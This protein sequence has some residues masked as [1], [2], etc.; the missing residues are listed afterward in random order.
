[1]P[2]FIEL[3]RSSKIKGPQQVGFNQDTWDDVYAKISCPDAIDQ[4]LHAAGIWFGQEFTK[5]R[6]I[7]KELI[8]YASVADPKRFFIGIATREWLVLARKLDDAMRNYSG[9]AIFSGE[10][11]QAEITTVFGTK[12]TPEGL[13]E[14]L[15]DGIR[16]PLST[17][18]PSSAPTVIT[19]PIAA[20]DAAAK[21]FFTAQLYH[22]LEQLWLDLTWNDYRF[23]EKDGNI[24]ILPSN[25][26]VHRAKAISGFRRQA[27]QVETIHTAV[28]IWKHKLPEEIRNRGLLERKLFSIIKKP[29]GKIRIKVS[30]AARHRDNPYAAP[31]QHIFLTHPYTDEYVNHAAPQLNNLTI[32]Q[33]LI[34]YDL[35]SQLPRQMA[36]FLPSDT[37]IGTIED[38]MAC[39]PELEREELYNAFRKALSISD[40]QA[41]FLIDRMTHRGSVR[42]QLWFKPII[43]LGNGRI[44]LFLPAIDGIHFYR[45]LDSILKEIPNAEGEMGELF[46]NYVRKKL[47]EASRNYQF[48]PDLRVYPKSFHLLGQN[49]TFEQID[50]V[51][52]LGH[53]VFVGE[54][55]ASIFPVE[56]LETYNYL[57]KLKTEA[58]A[59]ATRKAQFIRDH[60]PE[61]LAK[62][63]F[64][65]DPAAI[66][67][68]P[69]VVTNG[70]LY[71][72]YPMDGV[73]IC[74]LLILTRYFRE[75]NLPKLV[76]VDTHGNQT[77]NE[78]QQF[79]TSSREAI[80]NLNQYLMH[81]PQVQVY[82][83]SLALLERPMPSIPGQSVSFKEYEVRMDYNALKSKFAN[84]QSPTSSLVD[85]Q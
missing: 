56:P 15:V 27:L 25:D 53:K 77:P 10:L 38:A 49:K 52:T 26:P 58:A 43:D 60:I 48:A 76:A 11:A 33:V 7:N 51:F 47:V 35:L 65:M 6:E 30:E 63:G 74:D 9:S 37:S 45:L 29:S 81:P 20:F 22:V 80:E 19:N 85:V 39:T 67:V 70:N 59:Q 18:E 36:H 64:P 34:A 40:E 44:S 79:Y 13:I 3:V 2:K 1:M 61:F 82:E 41:L 73:P 24:V 8:L 32:R 57:Q 31:I 5:I 62:V 4:S 68:S 12:V 54:C 84:S 14:T 75:G 66:S 16:F 69:L 46:E 71:C 17:I 50:L 83:N 72:G 21:L 28:N 23:E 42:D 55:K 78:V